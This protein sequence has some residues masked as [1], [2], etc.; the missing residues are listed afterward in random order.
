VT[1]Y[2]ATLAHDTQFENQGETRPVRGNGR[3][4]N[5][6]V[7]KSQGPAAVTTAV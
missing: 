4:G 1:G 2:P 3:P 6:F 7:G 5:G